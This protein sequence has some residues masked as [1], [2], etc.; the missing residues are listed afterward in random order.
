MLLSLLLACQSVSPNPP[1]PRYTVRVESREV[2]EIP[3]K[4]TGAEMPH[5]RLYGTLLSGP[6]SG[7]PWKTRLDYTETLAAPDGALLVLQ[8]SPMH[9]RVISL[10]DQAIWQDKSQRSP[11]DDRPFNVPVISPR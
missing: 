9:P 8:G 5:L 4:K 2:V 10:D 7:R 3:D 1:P 11:V 6:D